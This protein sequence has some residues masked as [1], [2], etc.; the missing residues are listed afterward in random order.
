MRFSSFTYLV[1]QGLHNLRRQPADDLCLHGRADRLHV[2]DRR[3]LRCWASTLTHMVEYI[4]NQNLTV[5]YMG[6]T[7]EARSPPTSRL[8]PPTR[9]SATLSPRGERDLYVAGGRSGDLQRYAEGLHKPA[10]GLSPMTTRSTPNYRVDRGRAPT[11][12]RKS[13]PQLHADRRRLPASRPRWLWRIPS[14]LAA[15]G[16]QLRLLRH[17]SRC[18]PS[19]PSSSSTTRSKSPS[20]TAARRSAL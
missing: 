5:V 20:L 3:R 12:L 2:A 1:G 15:E 19:S 7:G 18:W 14:R 17:W 8:P 11:T 16:H 9:P 10:A 4:G 13:P 6:G